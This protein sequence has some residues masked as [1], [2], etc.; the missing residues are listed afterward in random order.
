MTLLKSS[1]P[2]LA[3][4]FLLSK[5]SEGFLSFI[6]WVSVL[7]VALGVLALTVVTNVINGFEN[8]LTRAI[9]GMNGDLILYS[10][11]EPVENFQQVE[12][13][14]RRT[15]PEVEALTPSFITELMASG[16]QGVSGAVLQGFDPETFGQVTAVPKR[17]V[18]G[19]LPTTDRE[20]AVG[21]ALADKV[22]AVP[23]SDLKLIAPFSGASDASPKL[24]TLKVVGI[25]HMGMH[26]YDSKFVFMTLPG[27]QKFLNQPGKVTNFNMRL[28]PGADSRVAAGKLSDTFGHPFRAKDWSQL[29]KNLFYAIKLEKAVIAIILTVIVI[30][31]AFNVVSTLMM[32]IHDKTRE[33]AILKAM[34]FRKGQAFRLFCVIGVGIG[35]T[36]IVLGV[37]A[38]IAMGW[39]LEKTHWI[40]LPSD[41]YYIDFLPIIVR[42]SEVGAIMGVALLI[43]FFAT[44]YP[45]WSVSSR[46]PL[47]GLRYD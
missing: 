34:G 36:G 33:I 16:P 4:K 9:T 18:A 31:A 14:I 13:D 22:G 32:M 26:D 3:R 42:W 19:R 20:V 46:S 7:G 12:T 17:V 15:V 40:A 35:A 11:G 27:V 5:Q 21:M 23:F 43:T 29:N 47:D 2:T 28:S 8:E 24:A 41:V 38:G 25:V 39:V 44:L 30:V 1:V 6:A 37:L 45:A 10:R